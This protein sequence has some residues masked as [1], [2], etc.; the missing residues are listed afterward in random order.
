MQGKADFDKATTNDG[1]PPAFAVALERAHGLDAGARST[2]IIL[3]ED[4]LKFTSNFKFDL[5]HS[6]QLASKAGRLGS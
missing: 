6:P 5:C 1:A 4:W 3:L 2:H